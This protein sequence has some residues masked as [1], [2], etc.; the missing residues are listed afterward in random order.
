[1]HIAV[2]YEL[3]E[4]LFDAADAKTVVT[5]KYE[6]VCSS[7]FSTDWFFVA[8]CADGF[9]RKKLIWLF[10][11]LDVFLTLALRK[12]IVF[13]RIASV[14]PIWMVLSLVI[15]IIRSKSKSSLSVII[16][17]YKITISSPV[18]FLNLV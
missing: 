6:C 1:M 17:I 14:M 15:I 10:L 2:V 7:S 4:T 11:L 13:D 12:L 5:H 8:Y 9:T 16:I 18:F 3:L